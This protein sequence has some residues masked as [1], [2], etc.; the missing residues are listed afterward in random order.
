MSTVLVYA[1]RA[2]VRERVKAA[3]G[4]VPDQQLGEIEF[5]DVTD[6]RVLVAAVDHGE[7]DLCVLDAEATPEGGMGLSRQLKNEITDCPPTILLVAR[8][9]DRW[10]ATWSL[11]DAVVTHPV[12]PDELTA[13]VVGLLRARASGA[14]VR[15]PVTYAAHGTSE[16]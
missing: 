2:D 16:P 5:V 1:D 4:T 9:D 7:V 8:Q 13:A 3:I 12:D 14:P 15:R 6:G 10:L 11:A